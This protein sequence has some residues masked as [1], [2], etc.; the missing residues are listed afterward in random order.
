[1]KSIIA[2]AL[3]A[4]LTACGGAGSAQEDHT[5][6]AAKV[7]TCTKFTLTSATGAHDVEGCG[8]WVD[9]EYDA[10]AWFVTNEVKPG[11]DDYR[12]LVGL[13]LSIVLSNPDTVSVFVA[14]SRNSGDLVITK[15]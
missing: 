12:K 10:V 9:R 11:D 7:E 2:M 3:F 4:T 1:M 14:Q 6:I 13:A 8:E 5:A 15:K